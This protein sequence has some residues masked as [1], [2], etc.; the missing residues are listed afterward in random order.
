MGAGK[1]GISKGI[2]F[3]SV[4]CRKGRSY[5]VAISPDGKGQVLDC[6]ELAALHAGACFRKFV[7]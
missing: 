3:W 4:A 6:S 7:G 5:E 1:A 2:A